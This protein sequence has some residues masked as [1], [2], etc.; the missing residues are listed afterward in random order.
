MSRIKWL[1][2]LIVL[3][4]MQM[5]AAIKADV[6]VPFGSSEGTL[7]PDKVLKSHIGEQLIRSAVIAGSAAGNLTV[8]GI[9]VGDYLVGV[10]RLNR[11][12]TAANIDLSAITSE[13]TISAANTI[14]NAGGTNTTG[15]ALLVLWQDNT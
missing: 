3:L 13:F 12:A 11:D 4:A 14:N 2:G 7:L 5:M 8:T 1:V 15:D 10:I 6:H 9:A